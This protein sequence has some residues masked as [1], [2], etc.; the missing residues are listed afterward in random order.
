MRDSTRGT[1]S[2]RSLKR[3]RSTFPRPSAAA[4]PGPASAGGLRDLSSIF[5]SFQTESLE[6][7]AEFGNGKRNG[8]E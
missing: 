8:W 1:I 2:T 3:T 5:L 4:A 6:M 7:V